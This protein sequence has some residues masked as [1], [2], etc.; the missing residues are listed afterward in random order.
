MNQMLELFDKDFKAS[1]IKML[2]WSIIN[3]LKP[4]VEPMEHLN[5]ETE[6]QKR[7]N[8]KLQTEKYN[9]EILK[10]ISLMFSVIEWR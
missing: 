1:A 4:R 3:S 8:C 9:N 7:I 6:V 2:Q 10:K 5:K